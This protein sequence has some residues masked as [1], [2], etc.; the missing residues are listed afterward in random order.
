MMRNLKPINDECAGLSN[1]SKT[2]KVVSA[3]T[4][5]ALVANCRFDGDALKIS[6]RNGIP[7]SPALKSIASVA[8]GLEGTASKKKDIPEFR[9]RGRFNDSLH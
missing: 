6:D 7:I 5:K 2:I 4:K 9:F 8:I 3:E 1:T